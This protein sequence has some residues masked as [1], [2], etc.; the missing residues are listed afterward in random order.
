[1][2]AATCSVRFLAP[3]IALNA[4]PAGLQLLPGVSV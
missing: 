1:M 3:T 2:S 4:G